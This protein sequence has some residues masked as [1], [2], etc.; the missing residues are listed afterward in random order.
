MAVSGDNRGGRDTPVPQR[1]DGSWHLEDAR[2]R[3]QERQAA[4]TTPASPATGQPEEDF[5][6]LALSLADNAMTTDGTPLSQLET[7]QEL[8]GSAAPRGQPR[9]APTAEEI[10]RA[11]EAEQDAAASNGNNGAEDL[12]A[13]HSP[14]QSRTRQG[15]R[16][17]RLRARRRWVIACTLG[18][19]A[20]SLLAVELT[21]GGGTTARE[22]PS[23]SAAPLTAAP[24]AGLI[25]A[26]TDKFLAVEHAA[27][28]NLGTA[29]P[30]GTRAPRLP[31]H[32]RTPV[33]PTARPPSG[34]HSS[35]ATISST[36]GTSEAVTTT[37][38]TSQPGS[39]PSSSST[40]YGSSQPPPAT[41]PRT[42]P[43]SNS[44]SSSSS[45]SKATLRS[46]VT[47]AG[48]CGCQ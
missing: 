6:A 17:G 13:V 28:R 32:R 27:D 46:L 45:P 7:R 25:A 22:Q 38:Q 47:G 16:R 10:M 5:S 11:L 24:T 36:S 14:H 40:S 37:E 29:R 31:R 21:F 43:T 15:P 20:A 33:R 44:G 26:A 35:S 41:Q 34:S 4:Q 42:A 48:T 19:A 23:R 8:D 2:K 9:D 12:R 39:S 18:P 30:A 3:R 1:P